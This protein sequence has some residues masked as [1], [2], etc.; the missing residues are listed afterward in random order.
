MTK[1]IKVKLFFPDNLTGE[2]SCGYTTLT[3]EEHHANVKYDPDDKGAVI[4]AQEF[5]DHFLR[6][7]ATIASEKGGE[8]AE[9]LVSVADDTRK[10]GT[11]AERIID[12]E[13][14]K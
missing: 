13:G 6:N 5:I 14:E 1:K 4:E 9:I 8:E 10:R 3:V 11:F 2:V 7:G 12:E